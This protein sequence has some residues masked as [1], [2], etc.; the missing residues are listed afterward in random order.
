MACTAHRELLYRTQH[1]GDE[2]AGKPDRLLRARE[3]M[4][5]VAATQSQGQGPRHPGAEPDGT[6][7]GQSAAPRH[8]REQTERDGL[9]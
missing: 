9:R 2:L 7:E 6:K 3:T 1:K 4:G 8:S 5:N